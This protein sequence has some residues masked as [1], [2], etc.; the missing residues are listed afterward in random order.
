MGTAGLA[1]LLIGMFCNC[2]W[3]TGSSYTNVA[4]DSHGTPV[5]V[6]QRVGSMSGW[7]QAR[8]RTH[9]FDI[10][11]EILVSR[12]NLSFE[13]PEGNADVKVKYLQVP[14]LF[15]YGPRL[16]SG[17]PWLVT[18]LKAFAGPSIAFKLNAE[19]TGD[20]PGLRD[21]EDF[22]DRVHALDF[23][24]VVG[25]TAES[26]GLLLDARYTRGLSNLYTGPE[27]DRLQINNHAFTILVGLRFGLMEP[28]KPP[29]Q[30]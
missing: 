3:K 2:G 26:H 27:R 10:Q 16:F 18:S 25:A 19:A 4:I 15:R 17:N 5:D 28:I 9:R 29:P 23:G 24:F 21:P 11:Y 30:N 1:I 6:G 20:L 13:G 22:G 14:I 8:P 7:F 12:K